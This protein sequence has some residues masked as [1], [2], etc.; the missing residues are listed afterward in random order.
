M[1]FDGQSESTTSN[2][3]ESSS[4]DP[5]PPYEM[6]A[7]VYL[8][9][10][11]GKVYNGSWDSETFTD[12]AHQVGKNP[13]HV[14][15]LKFTAITASSSTGWVKAFPHIVINKKDADETWNKVFGQDGVATLAGLEGWS[16]NLEAGHDEPPY[17]TVV[18]ESVPTTFKVEREKTTEKTM[19]E[20]V[21]KST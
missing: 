8:E 7:K 18:V 5:R 10:E 13:R 19:E 2:N 20:I 4:E 16:D 21:E 12:I 1:S 6:R 9:H 11:G 17:V 3:V 15:F 14:P